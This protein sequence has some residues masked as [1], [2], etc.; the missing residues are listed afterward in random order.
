H[1]QEEYCTG[2]FYAAGMSAGGDMTSALQC[3]PDSPFEAYGPVTY[4]YYNAQECRHAPSA[5][6]LYFHGTDDV[7]VPFEGSSAPW[8]DP[9]VPQLMAD[10]AAHNGCNDIPQEERVAYDVL[11]YTFT[12]CDAPVSWY[13][14][15]GGGHTWPGAVP[16]PGLGYTTQSIN[17]SELI[18]QLFF[19]SS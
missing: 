8:F 14:V 9:P 2:A 5:P 7:V 6:M 12:A 13:L 4:A 3:L 18:W 10:W 1:I 19:D 11:R 16:L 15:E 17:A